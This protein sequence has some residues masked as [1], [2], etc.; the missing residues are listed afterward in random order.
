MIGSGSQESG[1]SKMRPQMSAMYCSIR[2]R[3]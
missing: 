2:G 3:F 1:E